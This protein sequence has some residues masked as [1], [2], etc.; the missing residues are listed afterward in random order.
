MSYKSKQ[1]VILNANKNCLI[2]ELPTLLF[3]LEHEKEIQSSEVMGD[4]GS[5]DTIGCKFQG[6]LW[7]FVKRF[8]L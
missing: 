4:Y 7:V 1:T 6:L 3:T 5:W 8:Q 2:E